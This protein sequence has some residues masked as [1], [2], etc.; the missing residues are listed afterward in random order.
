[1]SQAT[2]T[3]F[4][5]RK[6]S[7][8]DGPGIRT[9]VFFK[10]CPLACAWCH[11]PE[12]QAFGDEI[13]LWEQRCIGCGECLEHCTH[14]AIVQ[15]AGFDGRVRFVT[16][17]AACTRCGEC[18]D[19]CPAEAR[20]R[21]GRRMTVEKVMQEIER[22]RSFYE[23]SGGGVTFSGGEPLAQAVFLRGLLEA[24]RAVDLH[25][26][27]DTCGFAPWGALESILPY[28][29]LFLYDIKVMDE[30]E[31]R[32]LTGVSNRLILSNLKGLSASG[33]RIILRV[34]II[35]GMNDSEENFHEVASL[36]AGL[37]NL[38]RVDLLPYHPSAAG[39]YERLDM[40]YALAQV[41]TPSDEHMQVIA[42]LFAPYQL[43][44]K[45]GG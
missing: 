22:D 32:R 11:N 6:F 34:P 16:D 8:H 5:I 38:E 39:K 23:E 44:V 28:T 4:D 12:S 15:V 20:T 7:L 29:D 37:P 24:C 21:V 18:I 26:A 10:G 43:N 19:A 27:V 9:T 31:H 40:D 13:M 2:G 30:N 36:A 42:S 14:G 41:E 1:M 35:P 3:I 33:A 45:I 25:T 17:R